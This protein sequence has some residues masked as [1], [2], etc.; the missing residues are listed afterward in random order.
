MIANHVRSNKHTLS[1]AKILSKEKQQQ[2]IAEKLKKYN[3]ETHKSGESLSQDQ[4]VFRVRVVTAFLRAGVPLNKLDYLRDLLEEGCYRLTDKRQ[5]YDY[6]VFI[7][8]ELLMM[9]VNLGLFA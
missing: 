4:Q 8:K 2:D 6:I 9:I 7:L 3:Q 5:M 1:K